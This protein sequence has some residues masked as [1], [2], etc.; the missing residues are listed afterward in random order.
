MLKYYSPR[1]KAAHPEAA[2]QKKIVQFLM[3]N[4]AFYFSIP[5]EGKR[6]VVMG[7]H[8]KQMG[9]IPGIADLGI[10]VDGKIHFLEVKDKDGVQSASQRDFQA[11]CL[12][13]KIP[14]QCVFSLT[15][16]L[17]TLSEWRAIKPVKV[18]A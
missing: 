15:E 17:K 11:R 2:L 12:I 14:Y 1:R 5:N 13:E 18:A 9:L 4:D 16:A 8:L 3:M 6:S 10:V 7:A